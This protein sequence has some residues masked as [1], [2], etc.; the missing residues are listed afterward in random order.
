MG[1]DGYTP[2]ACRQWFSLYGCVVC[3]VILCIVQLGLVCELF[4]LCYDQGVGRETLST[5]KGVAGKEYGIPLS[6]VFY[7]SIYLEFASGVAA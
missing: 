5:L 4:I 7:I 3:K 1:K 6:E 2:L